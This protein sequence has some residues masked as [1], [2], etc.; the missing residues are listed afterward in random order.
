MSLEKISVIIPAYNRAELIGETIE[1]ILAQ[2]VSPYE[3]IVVDDGSTDGTPD[4][5]KNFGSSVKLFRQANQGAGAARNHGFQ[6]SIGDVIHFMDSD[7]LSSPNTYEVQLNALNRGKADFVYGPWVKTKFED[8]KL[9]FQ[10]VV[11]QQRP[12]PNSPEMYKWLLR[13]WVTVFQP[14]LL[15]RKIV[16]KVGPY[17]TDLKPSEDS[18]L[19]FRIAKSG[20]KFAHT[21]ETLL[22]YRVHPEG[23]ISTANTLRQREDWVRY[24]FA[25]NEHLGPEYNLDPRTSLS[26]GYRKL[27][28][29]S[30]EGVGEMEA[31]KQLASTISDIHRVS[32]WVTRP[33]RRAIS[34]MNRIR[35]QDNYMP[36][37][38]AAPITN[39]QLQLVHLMGFEP[40]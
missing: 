36:A 21:P 22:I 20:A 12:V 14:C 31:A 39:H 29:I 6:Q 4:V 26:F 37:F 40:K 19:L 7:D 34:R 3:I 25:I 11:I 1:S 9:S 15:T 28:A 18:E 38:C 8:R 16:E 27:N 33:F 5:V 2:T 13:G 23:Q 35:F 17:R 30:A 24:L 32:E 10:K